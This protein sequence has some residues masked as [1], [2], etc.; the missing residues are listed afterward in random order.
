MSTLVEGLHP[1]WGRQY[2]HYVVSYTN[3]AI[4]TPLAS[5]QE[6]HLRMKAFKAIDEIRKLE[7]FRTGPY[8][9]NI[10]SQITLSMLKALLDMTKVPEQ[11]YCMAEPD[12]ISGCVSL[13]ASVKPSPFQ[14]EYGYIC[15]RVLV[16]ALNSCLLNHVGRL[17]ETIA[18]MGD[19]PMSQRLPIFWS[20]SSWVVQQECERNGYLATTFRG[21]SFGE[22]VLTQLL[23]LLNSDR[24][25][26]FLVLRMTSSLVLSGTMLVLFTH[27][28][29]TETRHSHYLEYFTK[30]IQPYTRI[31]WRYLLVM[32]V[33]GAEELIMFELHNH[34]ATYARLKNDKPVDI[35]DSQT[36]VQTFNDR[37][38]SSRHL[39]IV[40]AAALLRFVAP[41]VVPG[42]E[43]LI[44]TTVRVCIAALWE[45]T[46][47]HGISNQTLRMAVSSFLLY[48][49]DIL[50]AVKPQHFA[51][52]PWIWEIVDH[53]IEGEVLDL[54]LRVFSTAP[55]Y[56]PSDFEGTEGQLFS[57]AVEFYMALDELAPDPN[58]RLR[59][60]DAGSLATWSKCYFYFHWHVSGPKNTSW[61]TSSSTHSVNWA[62]SNIVAGVLSVLI[63]PGWKEFLDRMAGSCD[64]PRCPM[65]FGAR[66]VCSECIDLMYCGSEC[67]TS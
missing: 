28:S 46:L 54:A 47:H 8:R 51:H 65:P 29:D 38:G 26:F 3:E 2:P 64:N 32:P 34:V 50:K 4:A 41:L 36:I 60:H 15:F 62:C 67:L 30:I 57:G 21:V 6:S 23:Q 10:A 42:Y 27:L 14:Y 66:W 58:L 33:F 45:T 49:R 59:L 24:K 11:F 39:N 16:I 55:H 35:E 43:N 1:L 13:M 19:V 17:D 48:L 40:L 20:R 9:E 7:F 31:F 53:V 22:H 44:P 61:D 56:D 18:R 5:A 52:Q 25:Y 12:L 63:G 37:L